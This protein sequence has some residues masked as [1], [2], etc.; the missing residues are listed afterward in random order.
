[1]TWRQRLRE[2]PG[3]FRSR[4]DPRYLALLVALLLVVLFAKDACDAIHAGAQHTVRKDAAVAPQ[5]TNGG[6]NA[7]HY[8]R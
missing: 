5:Q 8:L 6:S 1:M 4:R 3:M 2:K 7:R